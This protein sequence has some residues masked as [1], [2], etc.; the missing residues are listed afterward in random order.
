MNHK[1]GL[2][3]TDLRFLSCRILIAVSSIFIIKSRFWNQSFL[4]V[5]TVDEILEIFLGE[6]MGAFCSR[7]R[8]NFALSRMP[9]KLR[10]IRLTHLNAA[11]RR[12]LL[13]FEFGILACFHYSAHGFFQFSF[14]EFFLVHLSKI[15]TWLSIWISSLRNFSADAIEKY[16]VHRWCICDALLFRGRPKHL[17]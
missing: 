8:Y 2:L 3:N 16:A 17:L 4:N 14:Y 11:W 9:Q 5:W 15:A 6:I 10:Q 7:D 1:S 12:A 13:L